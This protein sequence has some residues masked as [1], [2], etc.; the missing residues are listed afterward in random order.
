MAH[1][2]YAGTSLA[3]PYLQTL[4][5]CQHPGQFAG[6]V[7][8]SCLNGQARLAFSISPDTLMR[9]RRDDVQDGMRAGYWRWSA[10]GRYQL[11]PQKEPVYGITEYIRLRPVYGGLSQ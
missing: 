3:T 1:G 10:A 6:D 4:S 8:V 2:R 7:D 5:A 11:G 9:R